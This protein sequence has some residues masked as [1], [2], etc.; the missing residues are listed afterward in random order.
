MFN[1][2]LNDKMSSFAEEVTTRLLELILYN[3]IWLIERATLLLMDWDFQWDVL[4]R[5]EI[6]IGSC[7]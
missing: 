5:S 2:R 6:A 7:A 4:N 1:L 3:I